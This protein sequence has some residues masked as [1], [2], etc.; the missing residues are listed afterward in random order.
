MSKKA[1]FFLAIIAWFSSNSL[2][3][4]QLRQ[5]TTFFVVPL[6]VGTGI[7]FLARHIAERLSDRTGR[8]IAVED[9]PGASGL[10]GTEYVAHAAPDGYT[11]LV[12]PG[13]ILSDAAINDRPDPIE[14]F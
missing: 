9:R 12:T 11:L 14:N 1:L 8:S 13:T 7:D 6:S 2:A 5:R 3:L 4:A 10:I